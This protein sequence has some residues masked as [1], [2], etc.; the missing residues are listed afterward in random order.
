MKSVVALFL[1]NVVFASSGLAS[2]VEIALRMS[3]GLQSDFVHRFTPH[4][5]KTEQVERGR[6]TFGP[7]PRMRWEYT[8]PEPKTF[9]FD[10]ST[11]WFY[12]P[13]ERQVT[14]T[15]LGQK[16]KREIPFVIL[17]DAAELQRFFTIRERQKG[18]LTISEIRPRDSSA[19]VREV[20]VTIH[21]ASHQIKTLAYTDRQGNKTVFEFNNYRKAPRSALA[22]QFTPPPGVDIIESQ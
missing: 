2:E 11:S 17:S 7:A 20:T 1:L 15:R 9:V 16:E 22:F 3:T 5:L 6:V 13:A 4:G 21:R 14:V 8:K 10:G 18:V 19:A 12:S